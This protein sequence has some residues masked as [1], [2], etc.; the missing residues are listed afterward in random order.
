ME[1]RIDL[2][3]EML[4]ELTEVIKFCCPKRGYRNVELMFAVGAYFMKHFYVKFT[5]IAIPGHDPEQ[6]LENKSCYIKNHITHKFITIDEVINELV[7]SG[8][9][10][11]T[12]EFLY[13]R[14]DTKLDSK[15]TVYKLD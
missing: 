10:K 14:S 11:K 13:S 7:A 5:Y 1:K 12:H 4:K 3:P 6:M 9:L 8:L 2:D 15:G